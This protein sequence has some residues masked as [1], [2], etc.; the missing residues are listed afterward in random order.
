MT[1]ERIA[2]V[3]TYAQRPKRVA[4]AF[5]VYHTPSVFAS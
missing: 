5:M 4:V 2:L 3:L 1:P